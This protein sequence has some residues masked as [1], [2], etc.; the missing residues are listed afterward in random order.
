MTR[1]HRARITRISAISRGKRY[2]KGLRA[3]RLAVLWLRLKGYRILGRRL[4]T[5][6]G[7]VDIWARKGR[8]CAIV[9]VKARADL[10]AGLAAVSV[11]QRRRLERA[12]AWLLA[13]DPAL[14]GCDLRFDV[15]VIRPWRAP[16]HL[17]DA[18]RPAE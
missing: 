9:E 12:G 3:E 18:W 8:L 1:I 16:F 6:A 14:Q 11:R 4:C 17:I 10:A 7:E 13:R 2:L 5:P 15:M